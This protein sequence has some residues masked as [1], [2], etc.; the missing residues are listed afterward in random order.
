MD[1]MH[2]VRIA[3]SPTIY[4]DIAMIMYNMVALFSN[5][6][7]LGPTGPEGA[8]TVAIVVHQTDSTKIWTV[9]CRSG[10]RIRLAWSMRAWG[11]RGR[12]LRDGRSGHGRLGMPYTAPI[13]SGTTPPLAFLPS[14]SYLHYPP[15]HNPVT[16]NKSTL[17]GFK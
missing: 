7:P 15:P 17:V 6:P 3:S 13:I 5:H 8:K 4:T 1:W 16:S 14:L 10:P 12:W 11:L 9:G 2:R